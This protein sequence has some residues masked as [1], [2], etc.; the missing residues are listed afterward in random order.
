MK[1]KRLK[2]V[3]KACEGNRKQDLG[4]GLDYESV[5]FPVLEWADA[6]KNSDGYTH[7]K[8]GQVES[9]TIIHPNRNLSLIERKI[10]LW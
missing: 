5:V 7:I 2:K 9:P 6:D 3:H 8:R 10:S 1:K 4:R